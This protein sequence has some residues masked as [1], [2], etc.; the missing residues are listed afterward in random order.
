MFEQTVAR[1]NIARTIS[2]CGNLHA[3]HGCR[4]PGRQCPVQAPAAAKVTVGGRCGIASY[5]GAS[6]DQMSAAS[7]IDSVPRPMITAFRGLETE[8][9]HVLDANRG[10][11]E[12]SCVAVTRST[13]AGRGWASIPATAAPDFQ[14]PLL[15]RMATACPRH[16]CEVRVDEV[17]APNDLPGSLH[18]H[19]HEAAGEVA[20]DD[21]LTGNRLWRRVSK[22]PISIANLHRRTAT[23]SDGA[24]SSPG[25]R[26]PAGTASATERCANEAINVDAR[27]WSGSGPPE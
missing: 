18:L 11:T 17:R 22:L 9:C 25:R 20:K 21:N 12:N 16:G 27:S 3:T 5:Y 2:V 26:W 23:S 4:H 10:G 7:S 15:A 19:L 1:S 24:G 13:T 8:P 14:D 6:A